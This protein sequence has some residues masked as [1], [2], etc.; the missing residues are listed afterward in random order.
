MMLSN[1]LYRQ[2]GELY[3]EGLIHLNDNKACEGGAPL[4]RVE[5]IRV[6][7]GKECYRYIIDKDLPK[8]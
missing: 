8:G 1:R 2:C 3:R 6:R 5:M 4:H 7:D